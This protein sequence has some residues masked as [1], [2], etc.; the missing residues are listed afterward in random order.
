MHDSRLDPGYAIA[1]QCEPTPGRHTIASYQD[2]DLRSGKKLFPKI[3]QMLKQAKDK[4]SKKVALHTATSI[5]AQ[6]ISCNGLCLLGVDSMDYP[7]VDYLNAVTGWDLSA[8]DY[9]KTGRR[10]QA[11]RK[12]FNIREGLGPGDSKLHDRGLGKPPQT[13]GPLKGKSVDIDSLEAT[14]YRF[15]GFD[16]ATGGP[17]PQT[18]Q[19]LEID[20]LGP[21]IPGR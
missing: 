6:L 1:Y 17:T 14:Y 13:V 18:L 4:E 3:R 19:E 8:D 16:P 2:I 21:I 15:L 20:K 12:A 5:Y 11:L 7:M 10:I 9:F